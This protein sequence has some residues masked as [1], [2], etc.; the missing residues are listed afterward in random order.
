MNTY[1]LAMVKELFAHEAV[2]IG[3]SNAV[4]FHRAAVQFGEEN[5]MRVRSSKPG[6]EYWNE[7]YLDEIQIVSF[8]TYRG[9]VEAASFFNVQQLQE[10]ARIYAE[11]EGTKITEFPTSARALSESG[12]K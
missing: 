12:K 9:F 7:F 2:L 10:E 1:N 6:G 5:V 4:P 11:N 3:S 8:L